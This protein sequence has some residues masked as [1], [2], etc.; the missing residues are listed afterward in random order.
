[1]LWLTTT[2]QLEAVD[3]KHTC[4][5]VNNNNGRPVRARTADLQIL[6]KKLTPSDT[7]IL[8]IFESIYFRVYLRSA[9]LSFLR[10]PWRMWRTST[11]FCF[12]MTRYI[13][14]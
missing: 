2:Q 5:Q 7:L 3:M 11:R 8:E 14:R 4:W 9:P 10:A 6:V 12:S 1:M 13:T